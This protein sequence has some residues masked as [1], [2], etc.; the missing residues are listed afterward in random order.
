MIKAVLSPCSLIF[1]G[2]LERALDIYDKCYQHHHPSV[3]IA[4]T[5][6]GAVMRSLGESEKSK[7][8]FEKAL[9]MEENLYEPTHPSV[10]NLHCILCPV[11]SVMKVCILQSKVHQDFF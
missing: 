1:R 8:L 6:L 9:N 4:L 2:C 5:N 7:E 10:S 3:A 11:H